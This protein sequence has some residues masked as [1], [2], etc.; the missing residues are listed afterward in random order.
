MSRSVEWRMR[1]GAEAL[2][3]V[4]SSDGAVSEMAPPDPAILKSFLN[5]A[6]KI[7]DWE[8]WSGWKPLEA[9]DRD[10]ER[11]G[12]LV[13]SRADGGEVLSIDP[14]VFWERVHAWFRSRGT[15][16]TD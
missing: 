6:N 11:F 12:G 8:A 10:P 4:D 9:V 16:Y 1:D 2:I 3:L 13:L 14:E 7:D 5:V 15:D